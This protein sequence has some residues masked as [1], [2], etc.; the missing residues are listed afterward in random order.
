MK[1][2]YYTKGCADLPDTIETAGPDQSYPW[3]KPGI[4]Y[5]FNGASGEYGPTEY[6]PAQARA[7]AAALARAADDAEGGEPPNGALE[8]TVAI[9]EYQYDPDE[10]ADDP[11]LYGQVRTEAEM[12]VRDVRRE[13]AAF[14]RANIDMQG[15]DFPDAESVATW[16]GEG[17]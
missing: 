9:L 3:M 13:A 11:S 2:D 12:I 8:R 4:V 7:L 6:T 10:Y 5:D 14:I 16:L 17:K 15:L 1:I